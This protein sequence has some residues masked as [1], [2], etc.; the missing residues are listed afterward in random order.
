MN[1]KKLE[2]LKIFNC[3]LC[4]FFKNVYV[5]KDKNTGT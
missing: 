3:H 1:K 5:K 2:K 4:L